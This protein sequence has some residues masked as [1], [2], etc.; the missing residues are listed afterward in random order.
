MSH[1]KDEREILRFT[2]GNIKEVKVGSNLKST[3]SFYLQKPA[4][5]Y[6]LAILELQNMT[7]YDLEV[8]SCA[9]RE[10]IKQTDALMD[11][12]KVEL[13]VKFEAKP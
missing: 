4:P 12:A 5:S 7:L 11:K 6:R 3:I 9:I 10:I 2:M 1:K 13:E 8:F